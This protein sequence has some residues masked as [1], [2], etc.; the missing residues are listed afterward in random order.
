MKIFDFWED[1]SEVKGFL[2]VKFKIQ[3]DLQ[4]KYFFITK[5]K[6]NF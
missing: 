2:A 6:I 4:D 1:E 3:F 5:L